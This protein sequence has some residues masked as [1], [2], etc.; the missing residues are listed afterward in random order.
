[1][2]R[3]TKFEEYWVCGTNTGWF[4]QCCCCFRESGIAGELGVGVS[5]YFKQLKNLVV[6]LL[7]CTLLSLPAYML[8][9]SGRLI[10]NPDRTVD[11]GFS[12]NTGLAAISLAN[13][14][15]KSSMLL[16]LNPKLAS[17][18]VE[19]YCETG[20]IGA[21]TEHGVA[22]P[23]ENSEEAEYFGDTYCDIA[24]ENRNALAFQRECAGKGHCEMDWQLPAQASYAASCR[25]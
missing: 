10:N 21:V 16:A 4:W 23:F 19:M 6:I 14:G 13:L 17:Q 18:Q 2:A 15:E 22:L 7:L 3:Q 20:A 1:M 9:W 5:V 25:E 8:F 12:I 24:V 11:Q